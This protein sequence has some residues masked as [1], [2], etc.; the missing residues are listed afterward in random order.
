MPDPTPTPPAPATPPASGTDVQNK[1]YPGA[2][3]PVEPK[4]ATPPPDPAAKGDPQPPAKPDDANKGTDGSARVVPD[5][6]NLKLPDGSLLD[7][8]ILEQVASFAK[9]KKLT[10]EEAQAV[11]ERE[12]AMI[13]SYVDAQKQTLVQRQKEWVETIKADKEIG[14][15]G[16][17]QT[18]EM[19]KRV[20]DR[21]GSDSLKKALNDSGL[22]NHPE[23][24][25]FVARIGKAMS[26][27]QLVIPGAASAGKRTLEDIFYPTAA[28]P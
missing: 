26:E 8:K 3:P 12:S 2:Q 24:V 16:M 15:D 4:A 14:G 22:G 23:L 6:Y 27:D 28:K 5:A 10:N 7:A 1:I 13:A 25:R 11:L 21:Y 17:N 20:V 19:A 18:I 9:E